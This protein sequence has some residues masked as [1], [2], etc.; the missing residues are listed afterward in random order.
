MPFLKYSDPSRK[1]MYNDPI[2]MKVSFDKIKG[3]SSTLKYIL[4][5]YNI[6]GEW[7]GFKELTTELQVRNF[8]CEEY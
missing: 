3:K 2:K 1:I 4:S 5:M 8:N 7:L 6:T